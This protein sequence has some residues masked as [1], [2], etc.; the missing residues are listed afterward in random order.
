MIL[1]RTPEIEELPEFYQDYTINPPP[2]E[3]IH[4]WEGT[5][6]PKLLS[7]T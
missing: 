2:S 5:Q 1:D 3:A 7:D 6:N 4:N